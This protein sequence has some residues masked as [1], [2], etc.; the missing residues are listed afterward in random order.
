M[1]SWGEHEWFRFG[2][3]VLGAFALNKAPVSLGVNLTGRTSSFLSTTS[4]ANSFTPNRSLMNRLN[5][6]NLEFKLGQQAEGNAFQTRAST[7]EGVREASKYLQEQGVPRTFR[8]QILES[9]EVETISL[10]TA[11]NA[12]FGLRF[13]GGAANQSGRYLFPTFTNYTNRTGLALPSNWN[14]MSGISQFQI[15][16]GSRYIFGR[17]ASQGGTYNGGSFQMYINN[18]NNIT[19]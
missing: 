10:R 3:N 13:Y 14:S 8:K 16:P 17:T 5:K 1:P 2:T 19:K 6:A 4:K 11:D 7:F 9:F 18:L 15:T 12:T